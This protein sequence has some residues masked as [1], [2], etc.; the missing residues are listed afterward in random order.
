MSSGTQVTGVTSATTATLPLTT[1]Q[2]LSA[3]TQY[4]LGFINDTSVALQE[5]YGGNVGY[6]A[7]NTYASGAPSTAPAMTSAQASYL[8]WGNV[9]GVSGANYYEVNQQPPPGALSYVFDATVNHEDLY[10]F[11]ALSS[12]PANVYVVAVKGYIQKSDAGA[13]TISLRMKSSTTD[14]G[15]STTADARDDLRLDDPIFATDPNGGS[16][17]RDPA[18]RHQRLQF[19]S[20]PPADRCPARGLGRSA[21]RRSGHAAGGRALSA[22]RWLP[23]RPNGSTAGRR[24]GHGDRASAGVTLSA[25]VKTTNSS[26][27]AGRSACIS[28]S[29]G[30]SARPHQ[31][32]AG[33]SRRSCWADGSRLSRRPSRCRWACKAAMRDQGDQRRRGLR[34]DRL[35]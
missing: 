10:N 30:G 24:C 3:G 31:R 5:S 33:L 20:N 8:L 18:E 12:S 29:A 13:K 19:D 11:G 25:S 7:A 27:A 23:D 32:A 14:S 6:R 28:I 17:D 16:P 4:W 21:C 35:V 26:V 34:G 9:S 15:G 1:P 22:K 2:S